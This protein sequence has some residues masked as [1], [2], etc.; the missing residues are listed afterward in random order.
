MYEIYMIHNKI[1][2]MFLYG[3]GVI[4]TK[5]NII[6]ICEKK[7]KEDYDTITYLLEEDIY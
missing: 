6:E 4:D 1:D 7:D 3:C 2:G 5:S